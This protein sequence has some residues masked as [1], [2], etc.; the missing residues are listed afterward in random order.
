VATSG[1]RNLRTGLAVVG[2][3]CIVLLCAAG[4]AS[5][6]T[7][8]LVFPDGRPMT[9][10]S[11]CAGTGCLQRSADPAPADARG[12]IALDA[13]PGTTIEY[14]RDAI[15]LA[16]V[17]LGVASGSVVAVGDRATV[18]LPRMLTP[19]APA[20]D[21]GEADLVARFNE[22]R[23]AAGVPPAQL[24]ARLGAA[25]DLQAAW[26]VQSATPLT[27]AETFHSGPFGSTVGFRLGEVS[28]PE[29]SAG[30]EIVAAG[31]TNAEAIAGWL[32]SPS[33]REALLLPGPMLVGAGR[34][35][36]FLVVVLHDPCTGC[37]DASALSTGAASQQA[38]TTTSGS[39]ADRLPG[40]GR[41]ALRVRRLPS[42]TNGVRRLRVQVAC[43][44]PRA[45]YRLVVREGRAGR[46]LAKRTI[47]SAGTIV[48]RVRPASGARMLR[49]RLK[50]D[51]HAIRAQSL[52]LPR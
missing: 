52:A 42:G 28:F 30:G 33:H 9:M 37:E 21:A 34:V 48:I 31:M 3:A 20:I 38:A 7:V 46:V 45:V 36:G 8:K 10:G 32:A 51:R 35:G 16:Q 44:R 26:L 39:A 43:L 5:A 13:A 25:A 22:A 23:A 29:P 2:T 50:R 47:R 24:N 41:E 49:V 19:A 4:Q 1:L 27:A 40:C 15:A 18:V 12:E 11:A 14:R 6:F 17:P